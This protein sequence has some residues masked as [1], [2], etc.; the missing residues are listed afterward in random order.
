[1]IVWDGVDLLLVTY[2]SWFYHYIRFVSLAFGRDR[3][4]DRNE[5]A[6]Y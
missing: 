4:Y 1:M 3:E 5:I 6:D 2:F